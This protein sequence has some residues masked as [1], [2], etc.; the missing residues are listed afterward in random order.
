LGLHV[1]DMT[2]P[3][4]LETQ[5]YLRQENKHSDLLWTL[6]SVQALQH[7]CIIESPTSHIVLPRR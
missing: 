6:K 4:V 3:S 1:L 7:T 5:L 2:S